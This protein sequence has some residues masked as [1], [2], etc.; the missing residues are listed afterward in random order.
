MKN[1][2][3][4]LSVFVIL[5]LSLTACSAVSGLKTASDTANAFMQALKDQD[6]ETSWNM[7]A[8]NIKDELGDTS[9]WA[10]F[11]APRG[12]ESWNFTSTNITDGVAQV[13]GEAKIGSE[14]YTVTVILDPNGDGWLVSGLNF[15]FKE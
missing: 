3:L 12:F 7:L 13:D 14:T 5:I 8:Q 9:A 4:T 11:T 6:N 1:K 10:D 2:L 15:T